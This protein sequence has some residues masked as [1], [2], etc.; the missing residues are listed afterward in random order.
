MANQIYI[1]A[2]F[3]QLIINIFQLYKEVSSLPAVAA[4]LRTRRDLARNPDTHWTAWR[5]LFSHLSKSICAPFISAC[6]LCPLCAVS[7]RWLLSRN[8]FSGSLMGNM[9]SMQT[10]GNI[11]YLISTSIFRFNFMLYGKYFH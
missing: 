11:N 10:N 6:A 9:Q 1:H 3:L 5:L 2:V 4:A 7:S 8:Y